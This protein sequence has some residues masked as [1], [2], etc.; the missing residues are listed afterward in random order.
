MDCGKCE[1]YKDGK[2]DK[3]CLHCKKYLFFTIKSNKRNPVIFENLPQEIWDN[4]SDQTDEKKLIDLIRSLPIEKST[5]LMQHYILNISFK[6]IA[7]YQNISPQAVY[8][9]NKYSL[10]IL[11]RMLST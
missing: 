2:G 8:K 1:H 3:T 7:V 6:E 9:N 4:I 11:K 10:M 5:P